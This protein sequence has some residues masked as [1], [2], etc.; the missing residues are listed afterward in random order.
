MRAMEIVFLVLLGFMH[1]HLWADDA[2][3]APAAAV[4]AAD[5]SASGLLADDFRKQKFSFKLGTTDYD[6]EEP[7]IMSIKGR[8]TTLE[9]SFRNLIGHRSRPMWYSVYASYA[10]TSNDTYDGGL[11]NGKTVTPET[12]SSKDD[13]VVVEGAFGFSFFNTHSQTADVY[14]GLGYR[15][16]T[17][18]IDGQDSYTRDITYLYLPIGMHYSW[19][20]TSGF[21]LVVG[22]QYNQLIVGTVKSS[23]SQIN[24]NLDDATN[25][26][27]NGSGSKFTLDT[28][29]A[30]GNAWT[31]YLEGVYQ[32]WNIADS[33]TFYTGGTDW[34]EPHNTTKMLGFNIGG[35]F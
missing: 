3:A 7:G 26:Q 28:E 1:S 11:S 14:S 27:T 33:D 25:T 2:P 31:L 4:E 18:N 10:F 29:F 21:K 5:D 17:N 23:L 20:P 9:T 16:L 15:D 34:I 35:R 22:A 24:S 30:M 8:L 19:R 13:I 12:A 32:T 6:Y